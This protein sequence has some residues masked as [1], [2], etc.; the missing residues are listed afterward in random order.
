LVERALDELFASHHA[1]G[2]PFK[3][4]DCLN[5]PNDDSSNASPDP[6]LGAWMEERQQKLKSK[7]QIVESGRFLKG[8]AFAKGG[9]M[10]TKDKVAGGLDPAQ[11]ALLF[12]LSLGRGIVVHEAFFIVAGAIAVGAAAAA[13]A[14]G[15]HDHEKNLGLHQ[16]R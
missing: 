5:Q 2:R 11:V 16:H 14:N 6:A 4:G 7:T 1:L 13:I 9:R 15:I 12:G 10:K 8:E 3:D